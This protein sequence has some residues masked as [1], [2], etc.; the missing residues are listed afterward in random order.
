MFRRL[1]KYCNKI[2]SC[3]SLIQQ[4][5]SAGFSKKYNAPLLASIFLLAMSLRLPSINVIEL[6]FKNNRKSWLKLLVSKCL[7]SASTMERASE[8]IDVAGLR[9]INDAIIHKLRRNKAYRI[10]ALSHGLMVAA[11]DGH[12]TF[13]SRKRCCKKCLK[14]EITVNGREVTEYYHRYAV[15]QLILGAIPVIIDIEPVLPHEGEV[16]AAKRMIIRILENHPRLIDVFSFD[17]LYLDS[18]L[19]NMLDEHGKF[20]IVVLKQENR[21]AYADID[22]LLKIQKPHAIDVPDKN[23]LLW[24]FHDLV[25]WDNLDKP[26]RAVVSEEHWCEWTIDKQGNKIKEEKTSHWRW[27]TNMPAIYPD[28]FIYDFGHGRW[29]IENRGF[30]ELANQCHF[31]H[32]F[33]HQPNALLAMLWF[34]SIAFILSYTFFNQNLKPQLR[35]LIQSRMQF[36][37]LLKQSLFEVG[38]HL[39][40]F[41]P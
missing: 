31:D 37:E 11:V 34:I 33:H 13:K 22:R 35:K 15:C 10:D 17:A 36:V 5:Q 2:F 26:F 3:D 28:R 4:L 41:S 32:P 16:A 29:N 19:L 40:A 27:L 20:W 14:R 1:W 12:E 25:S 6:T 18:T 8:K 21:Q 9:Y 38:L 39:F 30:N 23:V 24:D 7:P